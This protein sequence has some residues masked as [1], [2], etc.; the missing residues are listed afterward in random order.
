MLSSRIV[1]QNLSKSCP[2][3]FDEVPGLTLHSHQ[4][5]KKG[6]KNTARD[7]ELEDRSPE[8]QYVQP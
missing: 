7:V 4:G 3:V 2:S 6:K 1:A 5:K 8:P